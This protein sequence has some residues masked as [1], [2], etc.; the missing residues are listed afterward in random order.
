MTIDDKREAI[1]EK[2][3]SFEDCI[4]GCPLFK[5][6]NRCYTVAS[7]EEINRNYNLMFPSNADEIEHCKERIRYYRDRI[8]ELMTNANGK[9]TCE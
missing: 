2:C 5:S 8:W 4:D 6:A 1:R 7:D 9:K 3:H